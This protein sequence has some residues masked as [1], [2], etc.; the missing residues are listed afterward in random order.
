MSDVKLPTTIPAGRVGDL[1]RIRD[2]MARGVREALRQMV[3]RRGGA[4][5]EVLLV[6]SPPPKPA[7]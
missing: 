6:L 5:G 3:A 7:F 2:A 4:P 1:P